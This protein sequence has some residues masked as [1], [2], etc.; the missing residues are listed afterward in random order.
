[1]KNF[2]VINIASGKGGTGKTLFCAS[3]ADLLGNRGLNILIVD[4]DFFVRGLTTLLYFHKK[5]ALFL[6]DEEQVTVSDIFVNK[7]DHKD[8]EKLDLGI[9]RYRSFDVLPAVSRVDELLNYDDIMP[10]N[11]DIAEELLEKLIAKIPNKY[12]LVIFDSRSGYDELIAGI[13]SK[14]SVTLCIEEEDQI[15]KITADNLIKQLQKGSNTPLFRLINKARNIENEIDLEKRNRSI[16]EIGPIPFDIDILKSFG[17]Y[18]FW[19]NIRSSL[20]ISGVIKAWNKLCV[21]MSYNFELDDS[22]MSPLPSSGLEK[23]LSLFG[24]YDRVFLVYGLLASFFGM[25]LSLTGEKFIY[26]LKEDPVRLS[27][28]GVGVVGIFMVITI[29][30]RSK[31]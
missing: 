29:L 20:Y 18:G 25:A 4:L 17:E 13:H 26:L 22:R 12:D 2:K 7:S 31:K 16:N 6:V 24:K 10:D 11:I 23:R 30:L 14:S 8:F 15:S 21:K 5:E 27:G 9:I 1:M 3:L 19:E 28:L